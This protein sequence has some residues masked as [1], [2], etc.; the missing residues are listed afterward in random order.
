MSPVSPGNQTPHASSGLHR[1]SII[2][3]VS[4]LASSNMLA[5]VL[6][7][8]GGVLLAKLLAKQELGAINAVALILVY[9]AFLQGGVVQGINRELPYLLGKGDRKRAKD[10]A[11]SA[12]AWVLLCGMVGALVAGGIAVYEMVA[13][14]WRFA[15]AWGV[16]A[17]LLLLLFPR[18]Y[19]EAT[20]RTGAEFVRLGIVRLI[21]AVTGFVL[22]ALVWWIGFDGQCLRLVLTAAVPC[23]LL[24]IWR[25]FPVRP[26][27]RREPFWRLIRVGAPLY[28]VGY[29]G[30]AWSG[31]APLLVVRELGTEM[32]AVFYIATLTRTAG[33]SVIQAV[34]QVVYPRMSH[35]YGRTGDA[36][37]ALRWVWKPTLALAAVGVPVAAVSWLLLGPLVRWILP[38]FAAGIPAARWA[39]VILY[40]RTFMPPVYIYSVL[41]KQVTYGLTILFGA[42]VFLAVLPLLRWLTADPLAPYTQ[43]MAVG[44]AAHLAL[45][46]VVA[47]LVARPGDSDRGTV[48]DREAFDHVERKINETPFRGLPMGGTLNNFLL[49]ELV[50]GKGRFARFHGLADRL[51]RAVRLRRPMFADEDHAEPPRKDYLLT[52]M[53][54][55]F[56]YRELILPVAERL[57][58][59]RCAVLCGHAA[60]IDR[61]PDDAAGLSPERT[62]GYDVRAW[63]RDYKAVRRQWMR[64]LK[65]LRRAHGLPAGFP[66]RAAYMLMIQS[67]RVA[68]MQALVDRVGPR[69]VVTEHDRNTRWSC[70]VLAARS[71]GIPTATLVHGTMGPGGMGFTPLL[72]DR[73]FC[74]G[75]A[76][77][78]RFLEAGEA[79]ERLVLGGCPRIQRETVIPPVEARRRMQLPEDRPV[80]TLGTAAY[81]PDQ[82][83]ALAEAFCQGVDRLAD[84]VTG[85]VRLHPSEALPLYA[86]LAR[87]HPGIRFMDNRDATLDET[88]AATDAMVVYSSGIGSDALVKR[89]FTV[90]LDVIDA[91][92][93]HATELMEQAGCPRATGPEELA[94]I[95][96]EL[97]AETPLRAECEAAR[98]RYVERFCCAF[99]QE[100][101]RQ[102]ADE[103]RGF[104]GESPSV[105]GTGG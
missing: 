52:C 96:R 33:M 75:E 54:D 18:R 62:G 56:R 83:L 104:A 67:Q 10:L 103:V 47:F 60:T 14:D 70:L 61:L 93:G 35:M 41:R 43:A 82:S 16:H 48:L 3:S 32:L 89:R 37:A 7:L 40:L 13:G 57:G 73:V 30:A 59:S 23:V 66:D 69:A 86:D 91:P 72:A 105:G 45:A 5:T 53:D 6:R 63:R 26:S 28:A 21:A 100:A 25:P 51:R 87:R 81:R 2:R 1:G 55:S 38:R 31:L 78:Q 79:P 42:G 74:W 99:G 68:A 34:C 9:G 29:L 71:R 12:F 8:V 85:M 97:L 94:A 39:L 24:M 95:V 77:R 88:M 22:L 92:Q 65:A 20:F 27:L 98:E 102:I 90:V 84:E 15:K 50:M 64:T 76:D 17:V 4:A 19:L 101:A 44:V 36:R 80:V 46:N 58:P 11:A 49:I